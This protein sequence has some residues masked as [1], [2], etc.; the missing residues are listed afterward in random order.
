[1]LRKLPNLS[2]ISPACYQGLLSRL[3]SST[4]PLAIVATDRLR[5]TA[6]TYADNKNISYSSY[7]SSAINNGSHQAP[8]NF[9]LHG[10]GAPPP[11]PRS[12]S[13]EFANLAPV[14]LC[15]QPCRVV[16]IGWMGSRAKYINKQVSLS[17]SP[18]PPFP[19]PATPGHLITSCNLPLIIPN[20]LL[21]F[22]LIFMYYYLSVRYVHLW[23][24]TG[25]HAVITIRP[26]ILQTLLRFRGVVQAS[27]HS[28]AVSMVARIARR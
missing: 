28:K 3:V 16:V 9:S 19:P 13:E 8:T 15:P 6:A 26:T 1:M 17:P 23:E 4:T 2:L 20:L 22:L 11:P 14:I 7:C 25:D 27:L 24:R 10:A 21:S 12:I 5:S 18:P